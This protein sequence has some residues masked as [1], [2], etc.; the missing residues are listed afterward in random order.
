VVED[1]GNGQLAR[2][3]RGARLSRRRPLYCLI[4]RAQDAFNLYDDETLVLR[5]SSVSKG[6]ITAEEGAVV[7]EVMLPGAR[8]LTLVPIGL[9]AAAIE[10]FGKTNVTYALLRALNRLPAEW[11]EAVEADAGEGAGGDNGN[12]NDGGDD[13]DGGAD[14][15]A[16][17]SGNGGTPPCGAGVTF[18]FLNGSL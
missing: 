9:A 4:K 11:D 15:G 8:V 7:S 12:G 10:L 1:P 14:G 6:T 2:R 17:G 18:I 5:S 3:C 13:H 16:S